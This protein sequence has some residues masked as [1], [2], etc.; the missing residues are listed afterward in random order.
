MKN[1]LLQLKRSVSIGALQPFILLGIVLMMIV[2]Q[3]ILVPGSL[4]IQQLFII[5][6]QASA[7]GLVVLGQAMVILMG[8]TDLSVGSMVMITN[9]FCIASMAG[10]NENMALGIGVCVC[11]GLLVGIVNAVGVLVLKIAP[12]VMTMCTMTVLQ[13]ISYVYTRG[14][15]TGSAAPGI[16]LLGTGKL[17]GLIPYSTLIWLGVALVLWLVMRYTSF[18]R[19]IY[20]VGGNWRAARQSGISANL[21]IGLSYVFSALMATLAGIIMSG[22]MNITSLTLGGD[23]VMNSLAAVLIGGNAIQGGK[24]GIWPVVLGAFFIQLLMAM[25]TMLGITEVGKLIAQGVIIFAVVAAHSSMQG[26]R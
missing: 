22:Y 12:F 21:L 19:K 3:N 20:A 8:G 7:L 26:K 24:G 10:S 23:Y 1:S 11:I 2:V 14:A 17:F 9:V 18:G 16:R 4:T 6:R 25:L 5:S 13:G 15:P